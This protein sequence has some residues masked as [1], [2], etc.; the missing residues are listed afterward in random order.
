[1]DKLS[2]RSLLRTLAGG[3]L[4]TVGTVVIARA[5][6]AEAMG[7]K[8]IRIEDP[9]AVSDGLTEALV[10]KSGPVVVAY[11][12]TTLPLLL[13]PLFPRGKDLVQV[14][15]QVEDVVPQG[16]GGRVQCRVADSATSAPPALRT[17]PTL[18]HRSD[19]GRVPVAYRR[20]PGP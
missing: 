19:A 9:D 20:G 16:A 18:P 2:R 10:H 4:T 15:G 7:A 5:S 1:M 13:T 8:G 6:V 12:S 3:A 17:C 11:P 14:A